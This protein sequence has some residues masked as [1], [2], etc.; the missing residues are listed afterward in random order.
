[1]KRYLILLLSLLIQAGI[2][3]E[4]MMAKEPSNIKPMYWADSTHEE[5]T[6]KA[7]DLLL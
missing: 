2:S 7:I 4:A 6:L 1:M 3:K 5:I